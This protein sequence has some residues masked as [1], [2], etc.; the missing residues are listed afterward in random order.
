[1]RPLAILAAFVNLAGS[2]LLRAMKSSSHVLTLKSTERSNIGRSP[3]VL[4]SKSLSINFPTSFNSRIIKR[5]PSMHAW[6]ARELSRLRSDLATF[7]VCLM[8]TFAFV[9]AIWP[10]V[11][12]SAPRE[13]G[14]DLRIFVHLEGLINPGSAQISS[15]KSPWQQHNKPNIV[16]MEANRKREAIGIFSFFFL[17]GSCTMAKL[18][19]LCNGTTTILMSRGVYV[20]IEGAWLKF[21]LMFKYVNSWHKSYDFRLKSVETKRRSCRSWGIPCSHG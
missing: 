6:T 3:S 12:R 8:A 14:S 21:R 1:M 13:R 20:C 7:A 5:Q 11:R 17:S 18:L 15:I 16:E 2:P 9:T 4:P 10:N 19:R